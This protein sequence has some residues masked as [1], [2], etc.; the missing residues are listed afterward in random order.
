MFINIICGT[1]GTD[2]GKMDNILTDQDFMFKSTFKQEP[3]GMVYTCTLQR[4]QLTTLGYYCV[5]MLL[6]SSYC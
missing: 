1:V 3:T 6:V 4:F 5:K 2:E